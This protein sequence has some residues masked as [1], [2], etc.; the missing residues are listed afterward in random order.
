MKEHNFKICFDQKK[1]PKTEKAVYYQCSRCQ[2]KTQNFYRWED[3]T[4]YI[5][6]LKKEFPVCKKKIDC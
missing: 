1:E 5:D 6:K 3:R 4:D 2:L